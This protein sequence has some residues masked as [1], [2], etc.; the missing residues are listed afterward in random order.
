MISRYGTF[1]FCRDLPE[2]F[3]LR[4]AAAIELLHT[5]DGAARVTTRCGGMR[6]KRDSGIGAHQD[7]ER[8]Y[9]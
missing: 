8:K 7:E 6:R 3:D 9:D 1:V 4:E 2:R 5:L